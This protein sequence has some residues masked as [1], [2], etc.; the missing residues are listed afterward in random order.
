MPTISAFRLIGIALPEKTTNDYGRSAVDCG[1]LWHRFMSED[2]L[3]KIPALMS[4]EIHAVYHD[5]DG[6]HTQPFAFFLGGQVP[7][8]TQATEGLVALDI[9]AGDYDVVTAKGVLPGSVMKA[10]SGIWTSDMPRAYRPD[11]EVYGEKTMDPEH[12]EV[13]IYISVKRSLI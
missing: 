10:W 9:P 4:P 5:Y 6:D 12:S 3:S 7:A 1:G 11:F 8:G 13:D 2:I